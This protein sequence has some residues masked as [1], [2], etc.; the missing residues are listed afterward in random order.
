[1][2]LEQWGFDV[3]HSSISFWVRHLMVS[4]VHG[5]FTTWTGTLEFDEANPAASRLEVEIDVASIDTREPQR[6]AHLRS[7]DFFDAAKYPHITFK[8]AGAAPAGSRRFRVNG[9]L[10]IHGVSRP[11]TL[12]VEYAGRVKDPWGGERA[13]FS[14]RTTINRKDYGLTWNQVI[15]GG[16]IMV[17]DKVEISI[18]AEAVRS[19]PTG[20]GRG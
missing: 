14:A 16:G 19:Q 6:D 10:T 18:E 13:G 3:A 2:A 9:D 1:M 5:R 17:D 20:A 12:D 11:V 4:K 8:A 7:P 15:E